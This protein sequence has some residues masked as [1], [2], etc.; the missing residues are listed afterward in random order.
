VTG[1]V[2]LVYLGHVEP[3]LARHMQDEGMLVP[4]STEVLP[5]NARFATMSIDEQYTDGGYTF[6]RAS[7]DV[8]LGRRYVQG[9]RR[10][11]H[12]PVHRRRGGLRQVLLVS[13]SQHVPL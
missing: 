4:E 13:T 2:E 9:H 11:E 10:A 6:E 1:G 7:A 3:G 12:Q 5:A 8:L